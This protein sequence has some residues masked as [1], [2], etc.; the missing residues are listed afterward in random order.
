[1]EYALFD[2][3]IGRSRETQLTLLFPDETVGT[4]THYT[5]LR[6]WRDRPLPPLPTTRQRSQSTGSRRYFSFWR[7]LCL[8]LR[9]LFSRRKSDTEPL[10]A[11]PTQ[12]DGE[13]MTE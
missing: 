3:F 13:P 8:L 7:G 1:M 12:Q 10:L 2:H 4:T 9:R 5:P 11:S 6:Q